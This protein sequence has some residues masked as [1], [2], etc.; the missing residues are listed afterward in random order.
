MPVL[1]SA[2]LSTWYRLRNA[3]NPTI[4]YLFESW[5]EQQVQE[6]SPRQ[7]LQ[8]DIGVRVMDVGGM[9]YQ[10]SINSPVLIV[11]YPVYQ[12]TTANDGT[13]DRVSSALPLLGA[14]MSSIQAPITAANAPVFV[15]ENANLTMSEAGVNVSINYISTARGA[16]LPEFNTGDLDYIARTAR[17]YD[18]NLYISSNAFNMTYQVIEASVDIRADIGKVYLIG[19]SQAP[20]FAVKGYQVSGTV[21]ILMNPSEYEAFLALTGGAGFMPA[22]VV[23]N[24]RATTAATSFLTR[25]FEFLVGNS[26][27]YDSLRFGRTYISKN[28]ERTLAPGE[29]TKVKISFETYTNAS[30]PFTYVDRRPPAAPIYL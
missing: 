23:G 25:Q 17:F 16:F 14:S 6:V 28:I 29:L 10:Y 22:Q 5:S 13:R 30:T 19:T 15:L 20:Y 8:S 18:T 21:T 4:T 9:W 12:E 26:S 27:N 1:P 2:Y 7:L 11:E 3:F 24:L